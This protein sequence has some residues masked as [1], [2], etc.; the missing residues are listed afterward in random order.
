LSFDRPPAGASPKPLLLLIDEAG[1]TGIPNL[2]DHTTTVAGRGI[3]LWI[4]IQS[5]SQLSEHYG[6]Y[7]ADTLQNNCD[8]QIFYRQKSQETAEYLERVLGKKSAFARSQTSH[9][10]RETSEGAAE[11]AVP[12]KTAQEV[13][14]MDEEIIGFHGNL[15]PF[16]ARRMDWRRFP[17]LVRRQT[18]PPPTLTAVPPLPHT[19]PEVFYE[20]AAHASPYINPDHHIPG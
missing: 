4:A 7:G 6:V 15:P 19:E 18:L 2:P 14:Q 9:A 20:R 5:L 1:R 10:G 16:E 12:L 11:Q 17:E 8:S 3:T 13:M